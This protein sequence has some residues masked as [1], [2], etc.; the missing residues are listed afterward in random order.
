LSPRPA[1]RRPRTSTRLSC[2]RLTGAP[3]QSLVKK[4]LQEVWAS[5][6]GAAEIR[7][8]SRWVAFITGARE[9]GV[10]LEDVQDAAG[11]ADPRT[12]RR[13]DGMTVAVSHAVSV[14][15]RSCR[16]RLA[17]GTWT[18]RRQIVGVLRNSLRL[19][20]VDVR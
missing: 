18:Y 13:Y 20:S 4:L 16:S 10:P 17:S 3:G 2:E 14:N 11:H 9:A 5:L 8:H 1:L 6:D 12:T 19:M 15:V 7:P